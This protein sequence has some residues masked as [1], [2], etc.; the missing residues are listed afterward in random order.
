MGGEH[1]P[2][3]VWVQCKL[4]ISVCVCGWEGGVTKDALTRNDYISVTAS[5]SLLRGWGEGVLGTLVS[6]AHFSHSIRH[7]LYFDVI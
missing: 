7:T 4:S 3:L 6:G 1:H 5:P 2:V